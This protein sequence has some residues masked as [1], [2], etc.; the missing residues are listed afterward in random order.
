MEKF[1]IPPRH[2]APHLVASI[3]QSADAMQLVAQRRNVPFGLM[4]DH[5]PFAR[6]H[7]PAITLMRGSFASLRRVHRPADSLDH[8]SGRGIDTAVQLLRASLALLRQ[9]AAALPLVGNRPAR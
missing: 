5:L 9:E 1:G 3:L 7:L 2:I 8:M 4:L 6:A